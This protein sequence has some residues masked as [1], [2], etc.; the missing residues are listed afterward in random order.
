MTGRLAAFALAMIVTALLAWWSP[1]LDRP[2]TRFEVARGLME[3]GR[4]ELAVHLFD[5]PTWRGVAHYR[6]GRFRRALGEFFLEET[7]LSLY[8]MGTAYARLQEW[9]GAVAAYQK[10]LRLEPGHADARHNLAI[11]IEAAA[12]SRRL[13]SEARSERRLGQ[14][15]DG[16][17]DRP[18]DDPGEAETV[19]EGQAGKREVRGSGAG[20]AASGTSRRPGIP[21]D[22]AFSE[23]PGA[24]ASLADSQEPGE[25][26]EDVA[27]VSALLLARESRLAAEILLRQI[28]DDP[29][30]VLA[31]RLYHAHRS[32]L[33]RE[34][35]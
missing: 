8:N 14:W 2:P 5:H 15:K 25:P 34:Q 9:D 28:N 3:E 32:R 18:E 21:G 4:A 11:V 26:P 19:E 31:A 33:A 30:R 27:G 17:R 16:Q 29:A 13:A 6:A 22:Q 24:G 23:D 10:V 35:P 12:L 1:R 20:T 7:P